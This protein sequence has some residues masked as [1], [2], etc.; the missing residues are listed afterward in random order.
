MF[1]VEEELICQ[2]SASSEWRTPTARALRWWF[3]H[4]ITG[5]TVSNPDIVW[6]LQMSLIQFTHQQ[7]LLERM[8]LDVSHEQTT[9]G[10]SVNEREG[11][12][13][14]EQDW[15]DGLHLAKRDSTEGLCKISKCLPLIWHDQLF[16]WINL[17][18]YYKAFQYA[19]K[20]VWHFIM[21]KLKLQFI[22]LN[23]SIQ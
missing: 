9:G 12:I 6:P 15:S 4:F 7:V 13:S 11:E 8:S 1:A 14:D 18:W 20:D 21:L 17:R 5:R 3:H 16:P 10:R 2:L 19:S 23:V 22:L